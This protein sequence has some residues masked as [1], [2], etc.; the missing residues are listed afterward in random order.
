ML[1]GVDLLKCNLCTSPV[2]LDVFTKLF[3]CGCS[4]FLRI[5]KQHIYAVAFQTHQHLKS[6]DIL[7]AVSQEGI[8]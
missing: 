6:S 1:A 7:Y 4:M 8:K 3:D 5:H 2:L